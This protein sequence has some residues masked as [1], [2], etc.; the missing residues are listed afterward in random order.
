MSLGILAGGAARR[1]GGQ[2]KGL[3]EIEGESLIARAARRL[4]D[5]DTFLLG[6]PAGPY[7]E[8]G[9]PT[10]PDLIAGKG[11]PGGVL[12]AIR[13][14]RDPWVFVIACDMPN[15]DDEARSGLIALRQAP[16][17]LYRCEGR[18]QPLAGWWH[19]DAAE[20]IEAAMES[21]WGLTRIARA[22]EACV[23]ETD[24]GD[25]FENLNRPEDLSEMR[26]RRA[27]PAAS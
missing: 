8:L 11:A 20:Q 26:R 6:D 4:P 3:I 24:R 19:R 9:W 15:V 10:Y 16:A 13:R 7:A 23:V 5:A 14:A 27:G 2:A 21:N 1:M 17:T 12:T 22:L 25:W 18:L